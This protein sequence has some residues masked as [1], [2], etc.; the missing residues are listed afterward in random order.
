MSLI[1]ITLEGHRDKVEE[2]VSL[3]RDFEPAEGYYLAF[4]GGKDSCV[5]KAL[6]D[7]AGVKYEAHYSVTSVDPPELVRFIRKHHPD[8]IFDVPHYND[9]RPITM[10]NLIPK[11]KMPPT[12]LARYC[13]AVLK[14]TGGKGRVVLTGVRWAESINRT[15]NRGLSES[16]ILK[17]LSHLLQKWE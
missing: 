2:A 11:K 4:S 6:C 1:E 10:W 7:M 3:L 12:R 9:G 14:E 13:C 16:A 8:V 15:K 5:V 17:V